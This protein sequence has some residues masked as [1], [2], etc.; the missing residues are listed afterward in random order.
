MADVDPMI[1][2]AYRRRYS[3]EE[4]EAALD[5]ALSDHAS[6]VTITSVSFEG[7]GSSGQI[8]GKPEVLIS[9]LETAL[10]AEAGDDTTDE[11]R[12][13]LVNFGSRQIGT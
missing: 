1:V 9:I 12:A 13:P 10:Q 8:N 7:G 6:G 5:Q 3:T 2:A 4:M 11:T